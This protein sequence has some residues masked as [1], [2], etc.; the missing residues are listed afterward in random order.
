MTTDGYVWIVSERA[1]LAS[2]VPIGTIGLQLKNS[3]NEEAHIR[4]SVRVIISA[5][6]SLFKESDAYRSFSSS[7]ESSFRTSTSSITQSNAA[8]NSTSQS[9]PDTPYN[10]TLPPSDCS[11]EEGGGKW[12]TG[13]RLLELLKKQ[14]FADGATGKIAFDVETGDRLNS[15]YD[16]VNFVGERKQKISIVGSFRHL[17]KER[18]MHLSLDVGS[19]LWP[20]RHRVKPRGFFVPTHL[21]VVT[22]AEKPFVSVHHLQSNRTC[23]E[24]M[25][26][27]PKVVNGREQVF[28]CQGY[29]MD[30]LV[31]V[32]SRLNFTF[33]VYLVADDSYG[34]YELS[35]NG[36]K[37]WNGMVGDL[38]NRKADLSVAPLTINPE[39]AKVIDFTKPFKYQ[40]IAMIQK[41]KPKKAK[42]E[43]FLQPFRDELWALVFASVFVVAAVLYIL[44]R[45]SPFGKNMMK[46]QRLTNEKSLNFSSAIWFSFG[47]LLNSGIGEKTPMSFS[48]RVLGMVWAGFSMIVVASYTANL[49]AWLVLDT[50]ETEITGLDDPRLRNPIE[51][52][53]YGTVKGS[54]VDMY[55]SSQVELSNMYRIMEENNVATTEQALE[56]V[57][58]GE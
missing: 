28:C 57:K 53:N 4:D 42:L 3:R 14:T 8:S 44:D 6:N 10:V 55:F 2:N 29:C 34:S 39:R 50:T 31:A 20:G 58:T 21:R 5:L 56:M 48:A 25:L 47:V 1:L 18:K 30:L 54:F 22:I 33:E 12:E 17:L 49:A 43:S 26:Q 7:S 15:D 24:G 37:I 45:F 27:C 35:S 23:P 51:G 41:R 40:G 9:V 46:D 38:V 13:V 11:R 19:V 52:F 36:G 16:I 32:A